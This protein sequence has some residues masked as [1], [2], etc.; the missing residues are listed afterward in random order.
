MS[1]PIIIKVPGIPAPGG[2]KK[3][4]WKPGMKHAN[5]VDAGGEKTKNW[6][7]VVALAEKQQY[8]GVLFDGAIEVSFVFTMP[9]AKAS[10]PNER[11]P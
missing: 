8:Q 1:G 7:A 11:R 10:L 6:R 4:F 3:A 5:I 2:S 9:P